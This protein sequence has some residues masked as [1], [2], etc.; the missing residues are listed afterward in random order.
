MDQTAERIGRGSSGR[1]P[2]TTGDYRRL[3]LFAPD[4]QLVTRA[5][6]RILDANHRAA[7]LLGQARSRL[8]DASLGELLHLDTPVDPAEL[9]DDTSTRGTAVPVE[10][11]LATADG[12]TLWVTGVVSRFPDRHGR[13]C[14]QWVLR[15]DPAGPSGPAEAE[16]EHLRDLEQ[17]TR[18]LWAAGMHDVRSPL[19]AIRAFADTLLD[20][21]DEITPEQRRAFHGRILETTDRITTLLDDLVV[22]D[23]VARGE[24]TLQR[25]GIDLLDVVTSALEGLADHDHV[26]QVLGGEPVPVHADP[27]RLG[28]AV[29]ALL[30]NALAHTPPDSQVRVTTRRTDRGAR[31]TIEDDGPGVP[32]AVADTLFDPF[33]A[34]PASLTASA[35]NGL[36]LAVARVLV[37]AHG[38]ALEHE[39]L[40]DGAR[41]VL[42]LPDAG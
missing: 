29:T 32:P 41:F 20:R 28:R 27:R 42:D 25:Q 34:Y 13:Q 30:D 6:G 2:R 37:E 17:W 10:G 23:L 40:P 36:G 39:P 16:L 7:D 31:V 14:L 26:V 38:G 15:P 21:E 4:P 33:V 18:A 35:G 24:L 1:R 22:L 12:A 5:D 3:F 9:G 19:A 8:R 11:K